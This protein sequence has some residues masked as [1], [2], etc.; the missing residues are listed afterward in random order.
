M[1]SLRTTVACLVFLGACLGVAEAR[2]QIFHFTDVNSNDYKITDL[3][4]Q[5]SDER[6]TEGFRVL[7]RNQP[8][9]LR[10]SAITSLKIGAQVGDGT[11]DKHLECSVQLSDGTNLS[12]FCIDGIVLG[13]TRNGD[14]KRPLNELIEL[15]PLKWN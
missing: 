14:Y 6:V 15:R 9:L 4:I 13:Q 7:D 11:P 5:Y 1:L 3:V 12:L 2:N 8:K 10:W